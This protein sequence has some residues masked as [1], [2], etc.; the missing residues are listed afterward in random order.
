[1]QENILIDINDLAARHGLTIFE[2]CIQDDAI[3]MDKL[4]EILQKEISYDKS[5]DL[6]FILNLM[7]KGNCISVET[8]KKEVNYKRHVE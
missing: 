3:Y 7:F 4:A 8:F 5:V 1:M 6:N 2:A